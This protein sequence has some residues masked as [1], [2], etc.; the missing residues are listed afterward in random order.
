MCSEF[1]LRLAAVV[2]TDCQG[3]RCVWAH[4][5]APALN[6][7]S[8]DVERC[9]V[10]GVP[11]E[12][13]PNRPST[14][15]HQVMRRG[16]HPNALAPTVRR[17]DR[18]RGLTCSRRLG[19]LPGQ[20]S[21][22]KW[23]CRISAELNRRCSHLLALRRSRWTV[24]A[25]FNVRPQRRVGLGDLGDHP[26]RRGRCLG[27]RWEHPHHYHLRH[28]S[29]ANECHRHVRRMTNSSPRGWDIARSSR[30]GPPGPYFRRRQLL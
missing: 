25:S 11:N 19:D 1:A 28:A 2:L 26:D 30:L 10:V 22:V 16:Q 15:H 23:L 5:F 18:Y 6:T 3:G 13:T 17:P 24:V 29:Q 14:E 8:G 21:R 7:A 20:A 27:L 12:A 4:D 9:V